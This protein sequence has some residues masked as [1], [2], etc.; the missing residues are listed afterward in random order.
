[1]QRL[2]TKLVDHEFAV[3]DGRTRWRRNGS[4]AAGDQ[5]LFL[6]VGIRGT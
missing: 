5:K 2:G 3:R 6:D 1:M 4:G